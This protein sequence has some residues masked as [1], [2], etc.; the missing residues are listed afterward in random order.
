[1]LGMHA[2]TPYNNSNDLQN[3]IAFVSLAKFPYMIVMTETKLLMHQQT[4]SNTGNP[5][6]GGLHSVIQNMFVQLH[7]WLTVSSLNSEL[8]C[9]RYSSYS[10]WNKHVII[11]GLYNIK[12]R[13]SQYSHPSK[14][15]LQAFAVQKYKLCM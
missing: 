6:L 5:F 12:I 9:M 11:L 14:C 4:L 8:I 1:M 13:I 15:L 10:N 2:V 3:F 7:H